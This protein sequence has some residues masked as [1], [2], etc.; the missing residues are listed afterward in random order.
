MARLWLGSERQLGDDRTLANQS[1]VEPA[2]FRGI[3]D[4]DAAG[5]DSDTAGLETA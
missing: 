5:D 3:D 2:V 1:I 4:V